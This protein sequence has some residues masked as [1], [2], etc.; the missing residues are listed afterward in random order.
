MKITTLAIW[1]TH[2]TRLEMPSTELNMH[3]CVGNGGFAACRLQT[4]ITA[5][6]ADTSVP[7]SRLYPHA[8][9]LSYLNGSQVPQQL[10]VAS[11]VLAKHSPNLVD[12]CTSNMLMSIIHFN[13]F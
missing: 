8:G 6:L 9:N 3:S 12:F 4:V 2:N 10:C 5:Q 13:T 11:P 7:E 1:I